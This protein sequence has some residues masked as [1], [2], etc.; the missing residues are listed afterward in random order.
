M[1]LR[2]ISEMDN[3]AIAYE[4]ADM[5]F[6]QVMDGRHNRDAE[7]YKTICEDAA[8]ERRVLGFIAFLNALQVSIGTA[9]TVDFVEQ[10]CVLLNKKGL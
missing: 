5:L 6:I 4:Y 7:Y 2:S 3:K 1:K 10:F 9:D 8:V